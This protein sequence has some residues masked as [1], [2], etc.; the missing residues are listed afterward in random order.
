MSKKIGV[1]AAALCAIL[2]L[3][4]W[5]KNENSDATP[6]KDGRV[7]VVSSMPTKIAKFH[8]QNLFAKFYSRAATDKSENIIRLKNY[9]AY[10]KIIQYIPKNYLIDISNPESS[11]SCQNN[12][13]FS[14]LVFRKDA[15]H[16]EMADFCRELQSMKMLKMDDGSPYKISNLYFSTD[17]N[18]KLE[19]VEISL[20]KLSE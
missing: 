4:I 8:R 13:C 6:T 11:A 5:H 15:T 1:Y 10:E 17:L 9:H 20:E 16:E 18:N 3:Y 14:K 2:L 19:Y 12:K 7:I